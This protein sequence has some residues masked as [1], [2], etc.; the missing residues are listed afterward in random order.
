MANP[1]QPVFVNPA[2]LYARVDS[3]VKYNLNVTPLK[4]DEIRL[5]VASTINDYADEYL[6]DFSA[7]LR[8]SRFV[9]TI[10]QAHSSIVSNDTKLHVYKKMTPVLGVSQN[11]DI[12]FGIALRNDIPELE[13]IHGVDELRTVFSSPFT[14]G[15]ETVIVEDDGI[16]TLRLM[17]PTDFGYMFVKNVGTIDYAR[18]TA[19]LIN[20]SAD[21]YSGQSIR[22]YA[23]P[24]TSD[25]TS[26]FNDILR[27]DPSEVNIQ[28]ET[29]RN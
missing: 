8:G 27:I 19:Q 13:K 1:I 23:A 16:G 10:D 24:A 17:R 12:N 6:N 15:G 21:Q 11:I 22:L 25:I 7:T 28:V 5:L 3:R 29:V 20:F 14:F 26:S 4:P 2:F 18:G 9:S